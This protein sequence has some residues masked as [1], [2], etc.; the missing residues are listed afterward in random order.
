MIKE[1]NYNNNK[2]L[3]LLD[4]FFHACYRSFLGAMDDFIVD[5]KVSYQSDDKRQDIWRTKSGVC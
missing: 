3:S 4:L 2:D 5:L 1:E